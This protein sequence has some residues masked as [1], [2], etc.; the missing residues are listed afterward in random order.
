MRDSLIAAQ[1]E[2]LNTYR[3]QFDVDTQLVPGGCQ[4]ET[5]ELTPEPAPAETAAP[6]PVATPEPTAEPA[7]T[8]TV[9][10]HAAIVAAA[11]HLAD[12]SHPW[13]PES[14]DPNPSYRRCLAR[15][16]E[17]PHDPA[18]VP[19]YYPKGGGEGAE[20]FCSLAVREMAWAVDWL[21][22][23]P[24]CAM[25]ASWHV[26]VYGEQHEPPYHQGAYYIPPDAY[27]GWAEICGSHVD[28]EP[29]LGWADKCLVMARAVSSDLVA[30]NEYSFA[31]LLSQMCPEPPAQNLEALG[32]CNEL[33]WLSDA[34]WGVAKQAEAD[35]HPL[36]AGWAARRTQFAQYTPDDMFL[37]C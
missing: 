37:V 26:N 35:G 3:C 18:R 33:E 23:D 10:S 7:D 20:I 4:N 16:E 12:Y 17:G 25:D 28:P 15:W 13:K 6:T 27:I 32:R 1:E 8:R 29:T 31:G 30:A 2:L 14:A 11:P 24:D 22:A 36:D 21:M 5:A 9:M 19:Y 34:A